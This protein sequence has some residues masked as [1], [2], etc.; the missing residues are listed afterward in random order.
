MELAIFSFIILTVGAIGAGHPQRAVRKIMMLVPV[1]AVLFVIG[2]SPDEDQS[3]TSLRVGV[4]PDQSEPEL[5]KRYEPLIGHLSETTGL[6][7]ELVIPNDYNHLL[8]LF[9]DRK[10]DLA[11]LGGLTFVKAQRD[12]QAVPLVMRDTDLKFRSYFLARADDSSRAVTDFKGLRLAFGSKLS[13]SGH[14]MPRHFLKERGIEPE[15]FFGDVLYS[16]AHD[17]TAI[18]VR[19][20]K[21]DLGVANAKI[22]EG[23]FEDGRLP[24]EQVKIVSQTPAYPDYVWAAQRDLNSALQDRIVDAFL[25]LSPA[26]EKQGDILE[27]LD[28]GGFLPAQTSDFSELIQVAESLGLI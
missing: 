6:N 21:A 14:L 13:T 4:L 3:K 17:R 16:G 11:Y 18:W 9:A 25:I 10:I 27:R 5:R 22:V 19:D 26:E 7:Y 23:M 15:R 20:R 24:P 1:A 8:V 28:T 12:H 2:C